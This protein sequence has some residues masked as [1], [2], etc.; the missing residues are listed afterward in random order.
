MQEVF[1]L[2]KLYSICHDQCSGLTQ[3]CFALDKGQIEQFE[4]GKGICIR[5]TKGVAWIT[6]EGLR[7]DFVVKSGETWKSNR[8]GKIVIQGI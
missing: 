7:K 5:I 6:Q 1:E 4:S 8:D 3:Y 2:P